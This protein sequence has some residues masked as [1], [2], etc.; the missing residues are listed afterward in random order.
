MLFSVVYYWEAKREQIFWVSIDISM[1]AVG[2]ILAKEKLFFHCSNLETSWVIRRQEIATQG[3]YFILDYMLILPKTIIPFVFKY[4]WYTYMVCSVFGIFVG[5]DLS[6]YSFSREAYTILIIFRES[7]VL[8]TVVPSLNLSARLLGIAQRPLVKEA[9]S[10][11]M[12]KSARD[13]PLL[14]GMKL[15]MEF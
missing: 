5:S 15:M 9:R 13:S 4:K 10:C 3:I 7:R 8:L 14:R 11:Q 2:F 6:L 12:L 1:F